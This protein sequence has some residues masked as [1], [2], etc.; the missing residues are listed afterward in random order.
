MMSRKIF[1]VLVLA[2]LSCPGL[3]QADEFRPSTYDEC[4]T[5]SMK[6]VASDVAA[7]AIISSCR[8]Q[9]PQQVE[10][11]TSQEDIAPPQEEV[12]SGTSRNLTPE[13]LG[14]LGATAF[15]LGDSYRIT[16][17][18]ENEHL[19]ITEVTIALW[20]ESN[21]DERRE[22]SRKVRIAPLASESTKYA[23][24]SES[25][26]FDWAASYASESTWGV[27]AAKGID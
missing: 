14:K 3:G 1:A 20:D 9:F 26:G 16:L 25:D 15:V 2:V 12:A 19:T 4:I 13:E 24:E 10:T 18:T 22:Y 6:G 5:D 7:N 11:A 27:T 17:H 23:V 8:N 21:P